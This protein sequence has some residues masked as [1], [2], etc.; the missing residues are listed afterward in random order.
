VQAHLSVSDN[1]VF[2]PGRE[3]PHKLETLMQI[4]SAGALIAIVQPLPQIGRGLAQ[5]A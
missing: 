1:A 2:P 3:W 4:K 5:H